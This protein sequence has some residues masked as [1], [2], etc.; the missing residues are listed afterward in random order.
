MPK[1]LS[2]GDFVQISVNKC[3]IRVE[4]EPVQPEMSSIC[5]FFVIRSLN[6]MAGLRLPPGGID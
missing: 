6:R 4:S 2:P 1:P 3:N 5:I